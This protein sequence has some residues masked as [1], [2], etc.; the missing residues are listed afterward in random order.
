MLV[1]IV[2]TF[3]LISCLPMV[4][5]LPLADPKYVFA[6]AIMAK[7]GSGMMII[8]QLTI[9]PKI[10]LNRSRRVLNLFYVREN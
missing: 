4:F 2:G 3:L 7:I 10:T 8:S 5:L 1:Y 9:I 6:F